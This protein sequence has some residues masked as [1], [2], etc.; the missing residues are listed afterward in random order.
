MNCYSFPIC[1]LSPHWK[2]ILILNLIY[3]K[4]CSRKNAMFVNKYCHYPS[5]AVI[6][7][8]QGT[9]DIGL[10]AEI[11]RGKRA[12]KDMS[13]GKHKYRIIFGS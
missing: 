8:D 11:V 9:S 10:I 13:G 12:E 2:A 3:L 6:K 4:I 5:S 1:P 7:T